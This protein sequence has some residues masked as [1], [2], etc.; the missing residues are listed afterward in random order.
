MKPRKP[1]RRVSPK[2]AKANRAYNAR[3]KEWLKEAGNT[4]CHACIARR[5]PIQPASQCHHSHGRLGKLLMFEP[6]W[7]PLCDDC[8]RWIH[9]NPEAARKLSL[10]A[11]KGQW[12]T[13]PDLRDV[14]Y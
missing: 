11:E 10:L 1:I 13:F 6:Y 9:A 8:H 2:K 3:V 12:N 4:I 7:I 5:K 14:P